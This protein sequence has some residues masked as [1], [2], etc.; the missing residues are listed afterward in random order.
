MNWEFGIDTYKLS[1][2]GVNQI[3]DENLLYGT[4][5]SSQRSVV[6]YMGWKSKQGGVYVYV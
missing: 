3:T 5:N 6:P 2:L 4:G 1:I